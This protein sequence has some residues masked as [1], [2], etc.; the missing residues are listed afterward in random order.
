[1]TERRISKQV[2]NELHR[3]MVLAAAARERGVSPSVL[4]DGLM[5]KR[6]R[7][8]DMVRNSE[9]K[10]RVLGVDKFD[11]SDWVAGEFTSA[12][13]AFRFAQRKTKQKRKYASDSSIATVFYAY[14]PDGR[15]IDRAPRKRK[16]K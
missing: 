12:E 15:Y 4:V 1:M 13:K 16:R 14:T 5:T 10:F 8:Q 11:R 6:N 7:V 3:G 2:M 9:G